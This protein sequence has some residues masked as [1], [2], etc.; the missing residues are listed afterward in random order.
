MAIKPSLERPAGPLLQKKSDRGFS[1]PPLQRMMRLHAALK[2]RHFP[3]CQKIAAELEVSAKT[4]QR[5][6]DFMRDRLGLPIEYH[7]QEFGF[8]YTE[9]VTGFPSIEVSEGEIT[10]LLVAQKALAQYKGT[11]FERP[12]HSAFRKITDGLKDRVSFSWTDLEDAISFRSAGASVAD[13]ELFE[14]VS[15]GVL[16]CVELEF[17]YR[18]L[19][20][21]GYESRRVQPYHLGCLENQWY[22]FAED[23]ERR[24]LRTFALPRMRK[25]ALTTKRFRRPTDFSIAEVLSGSFGVHSAGKKQRIRLQFDSFAARLV[26]ERKW[27]E[28]QRVREIAGDSII[29]ELELGG[30]EEIQR[31]ILSWGK[32]A[33]VLAPKEL[34]TRV[35]DEARAIAKLYEKGD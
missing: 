29:L 25:V 8:F 1:R 3:N 17:E 28:S 26:A 18:K 21:S 11:P 27:H 6:I 30:L 35:R 23:L 9:A 31:W 32:H 34:V 5:D 7:P 2:S 24:Q 19:Q 16:R 15:K 4:I 20:S 13:L 10:A 22:L 33:R 14:T 12:L